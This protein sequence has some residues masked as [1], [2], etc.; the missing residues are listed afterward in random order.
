M[1]TYTVSIALRHIKICN[2]RLVNTHLNTLIRTF[3]TAS[4]FEKV[5]LMFLTLKPSRI[6]FSQQH[7]KMTVISAWNTVGCF[8]VGM[9]KTSKGLIPSMPT[10][11]SSIHSSQLVM[12]DSQ[13]LGKLVP[14]FNMIIS[15]VMPHVLLVRPCPPECHNLP[16]WRWSASLLATALACLSNG[17]NE[18]AVKSRSW[19]ATYRSGEGKAIVLCRLASLLMTRWIYMCGIPY[20]THCSSAGLTRETDVQPMFEFWLHSSVSTCR[21]IKPTYLC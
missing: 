1:S 14:P 9:K 10:P 7:S 5:L 11:V 6:G 21:S 8:P 3:D 15:K 20:R 17:G 19:C 12:V 16:N 2:G 13:W 4:L 18:T